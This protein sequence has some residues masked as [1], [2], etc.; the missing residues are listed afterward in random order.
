M[1][2]NEHTLN[3]H[4]RPVVEVVVEVVVLADLKEEVRHQDRLDTEV[5]LLEQRQ[6]S[7]RATSKVIVSICDHN[8]STL[9]REVPIRH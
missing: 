2:V 4:N 1:L 6:V 3:L 9:G 8:W 5:D 7:R